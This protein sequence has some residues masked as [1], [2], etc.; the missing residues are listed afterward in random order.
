MPT[1]LGSSRPVRTPAPRPSNKRAATQRDVAEL[2]RVDPSVVSRVINNDPV[3]K[4]S[5]ATRK[6]VL[7]SIERLNY[8][9]NIM[10]RGLATARTWTMGML[11][12]SI[13][14]PAYAELASGARARAE[15]AGYVMVIGTAQDGTAAEAAFAELLSRG[16]V[17]GL[18]VASATVDDSFIARLAR[19]PAPLVV[20]NRRVPGVKATVSVDEV[21]ASQEAVRYL[22]SLGHRTITHVAGPAGISTALQRQNGFTSE[23]ARTPGVVGYVKHCDAWDAAAGYRATRELL[24]ERPEVTGIYV[25]NLLAAVGALRAAKELGLR[26]PEDVSLLAY[27]DYSLAEYLDPPLTTIAM[28]FSEA[29][30][31]AVELLLESLAGKPARSIMITTPPRLIVRESTGPAPLA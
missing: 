16:R 26:V 23:I 15:A 4:I 21:R 1:D 3:L 22:V 9:P 19:G 27:Q 31:A 7:A 28:A 13:A 2:A 20:I 29:G 17:D 5:V 11:L 12:P 14:N 10:A 25:V 30:A 8:L 6:R 18:I 24:Q